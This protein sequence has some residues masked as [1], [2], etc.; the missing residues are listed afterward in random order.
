MPPKT[1]IASALGIWAGGRFCHS[2]DRT[3]DLAIQALLQNSNKV[4]EK[5]IA[6][7][8]VLGRFHKVTNATTKLIHANPSR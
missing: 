4:R 6:I 7:A 1:T 3:N 2:S 8:A 5:A